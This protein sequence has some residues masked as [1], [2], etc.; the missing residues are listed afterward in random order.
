MVGRC[1]GLSIVLAG[2]VGGAVMFSPLR[3]ATVDPRARTIEFSD[4]NGR[5]L[6]T[7]LGDS[8]RHA[9]DVPLKGISNHF[10]LAILATEDRRFFEHGALDGP[11]TVRALWLAARAGHIP[12]GASTI[13]MQAARLIEPV[14]P[15][16]PGKLAELIAAQRLAFGLSKRDILELYCNRIPMGSNLYGVEA[17]ARTYFGIPAAQLDL[18]QAAM[19][20]ALP[21]DPVRLDPNRHWDALRKRQSVVLAQ[22]Q[23]A[24][25]I[26]DRDARRAREEHVA[27]LARHRGVEAAPHFLFWLRTQIDS[28]SG[29]IRTTIDRDLQTFA[30]TQ[31]RAVLA[32]MAARNANAASVLVIDNKSGD[33]LAYVGAPDYFAD[34]QL[35]RNDG[36]QALRQPG[37]ALKPFLYELALERRTI[38][39]TTILPDVPTA[40]A[41]PEAR[42][43][44][45]R[46]YSMTYLGPVRTRLALANSFNVPAVRVLERVGVGPFLARLRRLGFSHLDKPAEFYGLGLTLGGG[47]VSLYELARAYLTAARGGR[48]AGL[49]ATLPNRVAAPGPVSEAPELEPVGADEGAWALT[50]DILADR[51]ARAAA[52]G[53]DSVLAMPFDAAVKTGTSSDYRDTW[54]V[55]FTREYT[56]AVWVGNFDGAPMQK[57][58]GV[59]G[60]GPLWNRIMLHLHER[61]EPPRFAPPRGYVRRSICAQTGVHPTAACENVVQEYLDAGDLAVYSQNRTPVADTVYDSWLQHQGSAQRGGV[62]ILFPHD[63]DRFAVYAGAPQHLNF[64]IAGASGGL[65]LSLNGRRL[66]DG[67]AADGFRWP[68]RRGNYELVVRSSSARATVHFT[69][70]EPPRPRHLGFSVA[71]ANA[72]TR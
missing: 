52:F 53:V 45:P 35:G 59:A 55:G 49:V 33:I 2:I 15:T 58:S 16:V 5:P 61:R 4:R 14:E 70:T 60:A 47:E 30:E 43:Y 46:D 67:A 40:Y 62:R 26:S 41:L 3:P 64:R 22:M 20:A 7:I 68:L 54:T 31:T 57:I 23:R 63:G 72:R 28:S 39:P 13:A 1:V 37:S 65:Q 32:K 66:A 21:N 27:L 71:E 8:Q 11:A 12:A 51:H 10:V 6:G 19:L 17:A 36:V 48:P 34:R 29:H 50:T 25:Y 42:L 38:R 18:A 56:V 24:G 44:A 69:V 9:V